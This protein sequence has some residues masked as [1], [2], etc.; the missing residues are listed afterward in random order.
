MVDHVYIHIHIDDVE[1]LRGLNF[2]WTKIAEILG[3]SCS[4]L[5]RR[6]EEEGISR[7]SYYAN[8]TDGQLDATISQIKENHPKDGEVMIL[9]H[10]R[11]RGIRIQ[12]WKV[13]ASIHHIDSINTALRRRRTVQR[14]VYHVSGPNAVWHLD[15]NHKLIH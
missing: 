7:D 9:C 13:R 15:S 3:C 14:R 4:T 6:L 11:R 2:T 10:L 8:I 12:R 5:Y 1:F